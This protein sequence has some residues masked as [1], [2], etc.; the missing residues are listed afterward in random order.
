MTNDSAILLLLADR[1][2]EIETLRN[3]VAE[4]EAQAA[5]HE[6]EAT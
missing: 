5:Q 2:R 6:G 3:R 4:L 1:Q